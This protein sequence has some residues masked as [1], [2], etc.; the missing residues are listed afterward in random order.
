MTSAQP[1][2]PTASHLPRRAG[3]GGYMAYVWNGKPWFSYFHVPM[4]RRD[5]F[6]NWLI[7]LWCYPFSQVKFEIKTRSVEVQAFVGKTLR[8]FWSRY[9][10]LILKNYCCYGYA[11]AGFE[12]A[13]RRG[14]WRLDNVQPVYPLE[15]TPHRFKGRT[16]FAGFKINDVKGLVTTPYAFWFAGFEEAAL[17]YDRP[18]IAG[19]YDP[20]NE[21]NSRGG[22]KDLRLLFMRK[23]SIHPATLSHP[24]GEARYSDASG[25]EVL[26]QNSD[27]AQ[28]AMES[29]ESG[30]SISY[31]QEWD[32]KGNPK[33]VFTPA[34]AGPDC[35]SIHEYPKQ[36]K[37][38]MAEGFGI[39]MEV[40]ESAEKN[41]FSGRLVPY[42]AWLGKA[43][44]MAGLLVEAFDAALRPVVRLNFGSGADYEITPMSL[45]EAA[46]KEGQATGPQPGQGGDGSEQGQPQAQPIGASN[47]VP[48]EPARPGNERPSYGMS[49]VPVDESAVANAAEQVSYL[50][51]AA[52]D[53]SEHPRADD[54]KFIAKDQITAARGDKAK[55]TQLRKRVTDPAQ[56]K[57]L[58]A[59]L[60]SPEKSKAPKSPEG[61][62]K[63]GI[64]K[65]AADIVAGK[66][67]PVKARAL[68][69]QPASAST[70]VSKQLAGAIGE[71]IVIQFLKSKGFADAGH[72]SDYLHSERNNLPADLIHDHKIVEVKT[73]QASNGVGARQWRLTI[74]EP[75]EKEKAW[76]KKASPEAKAAFNAKKQ[77]EIHK[78]KEQAIK[79][80]SKELGYKIAGKTMTTVIDPARKVVNIYEFDGFHD[81]IG[82]DSSAAK[83]AYLG[84]FQYG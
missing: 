63:Q 40:I 35:P 6:I 74:G 41:S 78:R 75:G 3:Y 73:G 31:T 36:L 51:S 55:A 70:K 5:P 48:R 11:P 84:S 67:K 47:A 65:E 76:L 82:W 23:H 14:L 45:V 44:L 26:L 25:N 34:D 56:R 2:N 72:L 60:A 83:K 37:I 32:D 24:P 4:M 80:V 58:D 38:E 52:F 79:E 17:F 30:S 62:P 71:E 59:M 9:R 69:D 68:S 21:A 57:K 16:K 28:S 49:T 10:P 18:P 27:I 15:A 64:A 29:Y 12:Y 81:R 1:K 13:V 39:P 54:G 7:D 33:W 42:L 61:K 20:W 53:E 19:A 46:K 66:L 77:A 50:L 8:R 43:D 22:A